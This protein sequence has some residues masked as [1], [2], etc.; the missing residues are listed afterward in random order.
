MSCWEI[1]IRSETGWVFCNNYAEDNMHAALARLANDLGAKDSAIL[2]VRGTTRCLNDYR[3]RP[4][5][6]R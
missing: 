4:L 2:R 3:I 1:Q 5:D 6:N